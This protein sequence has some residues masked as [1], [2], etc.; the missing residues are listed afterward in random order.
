[1]EQTLY[2]RTLVNDELGGTTCDNTV[3]TDHVW[4]LG[5]GSGQAIVWVGDVTSEGPECVQI[6]NLTSDELG[7]SWVAFSDTV[8]AT[9]PACTYGAVR[10]TNLTVNIANTPA[11]IVPTV[12]YADG[13]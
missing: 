13:D 4:T 1:M 8:G 9:D 7:F 5:G 11:I 2:R 10:T 12:A 6:S 3:T